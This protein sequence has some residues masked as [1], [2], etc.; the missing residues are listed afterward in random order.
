MKL[1]APSVILPLLL[2]PCVGVS[3]E[4]VW[5]DESARTIPK[6][7]MEIGL[8]HTP[9]RYGLTEDL[10]L[11]TY[12]LWDIFVPGISAKKLWRAND[13]FLL[14]SVHSIYSPT[15]FLRFVAREKTGGLLPPDNYV[16]FFLVFD[17]YLLLSKPL[18]VEHTATARVG[19]RLAVAL[20]DRTSEHQPYERLQ[21]IDYPFVFPRTAF[22]TKAPV[23]APDV[24]LA[25]TGPL[26][27][28]FGYSA[29]CRFFLFGIH[30][31][32]REEDRTCWALEPSA[33]VIWNVSTSFSCHLG[34]IYSV[35]T[36]PFGHNSVFYPLLDLR[37][38]FGGPTTVP[39]P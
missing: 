2:L 22:L 31:Y 21:T 18:W 29:D 19:G 24:S 36:F 12:P 28:D 30:D 26:V 38:G 6:S 34:V 37:I 25:L 7:R 27:W 20:G 3:Q 14:A 13:D 33:V 8:I 16:P 17:S 32:Q 1:G 10:E 15:P 35:G 23:F 9:A 11:S 4:G 5:S 39:E